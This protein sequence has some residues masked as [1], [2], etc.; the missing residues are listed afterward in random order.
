[1]HLLSLGAFLLPAWRQLTGQV[2][3]EMSA[4]TT[5]ILGFQAAL[6]L[7]VVLVG[8]LCGVAARVLLLGLGLRPSRL[9][10][11][12]LG[13]LLAAAQVARTIAHRPAL[14]E[15]MLW[16]MGGL[17]AHFQVAL[18]EGLGERNLDLLLLGLGAAW[19]VAALV[20]HHRLLLGRKAL[21][22]GGAVLLVALASALPMRSTSQSKGRS[23][24]ILA[25]DSLRPDRFTSEGNPRD[26]T[27][28]LDALR[29]K[30]LWVANHFV[31]IASTTASWTSLLTGVYP[32]RHGIRDLFPRAE[33]SN[34]LL[35]TLPSVLAAQGYNTAVVSDYAGEMFNRVRYGFDVVDAPPETSVEV[36][37][38]RES[39]QR[40]PLALA[41]FS[42]PLG[43]RL[44]PVARYLPVNADPSVLTGRV[45]AQLER[46]E[47]SDKP[48]LLVA[49]YSVTHA[50][51]APPMPD[52]NAYTR[53][54]YTGSSRYSYELQQL[55]DLARVSDRP[56]DTDIEQIRA[57][58]DG[59]LRAFDREVGRLV[60]RLE[61]DGV[62]DRLLVVTGD[63]GENLFE[64]GTTTEH[65]KWFEGGDAAN[66][67]ALLLQGPGITPGIREGL[68][69]GVDLMPT[70]LDALQLEVPEGLD[71]RS[72]LQPLPE[73]RTVFAETTLWLGGPRS[74]PPGALT[75][76][77]LLE[78]LEV[79]PGTHALV[80]KR[81]W[82]DRTV[83]AKLRAARRGPWELVYMPTNE[84]PRWRLFDLKA[85][86]HAQR[87]LSS[88][89]PDVT[90]SLRAELLR[91]MEQDPLR[92][93]DAREHLVYREEQ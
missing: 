90:A 77:A 52:A 51:F 66:R 15:D 27:P 71:G 56:A 81:S 91:W 57:L 63:H 93:L 22:T 35:P 68:A 55:N 53:P 45:L 83:T 43:Q 9:R 36:F 37:A 85:D 1:M 13:A 62:Q 58:Y 32:H 73:D 82:M 54:D 46:L 28:H 48:F 92:W 49:F 39:F 6:V 87:D 8:A 42:G 86:P 60:E 89:H 88:E 18:V 23:I 25:A 16:R 31:P 47:A 10:V 30:S 59:S 14:F 79:E 78:L 72:L 64:P 26:T 70:L 7:G 2:R 67:T 50:P 24:I 20:R 21:F 12:G 17:R 29:S 4:L 75:Y 19:A 40:L 61:A 74:Q 33:V 5:H 41:F 69:S 44:F 84:S 11:A 38:D 3:D 80:L 65:G 76:P 34:V